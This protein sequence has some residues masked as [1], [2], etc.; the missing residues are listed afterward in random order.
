M[1]RPKSWILDDATPVRISVRPGRRSVVLY[2]D[3]VRETYC[4]AVVDIEIPA[5]GIEVRISASRERFAP[6]F[7]VGL[8]D[9][10]P[11]LGRF[12]LEG[13]PVAELERWVEGDGEW[14]PIDA[15]HSTVRF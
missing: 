5:G 11:E 3:L 2:S 12:D 13:M 9:H 4:G 1:A 14:M 10:G 6:A 8:P 15:V 7:V